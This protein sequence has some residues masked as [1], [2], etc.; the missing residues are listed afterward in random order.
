[1]AEGRTTAGD[2]W[3]SASEMIISAAREHS[4]R[5]AVIDADGSEINYA[6]MSANVLSLAGKLRDLGVGPDRMVAVMLPRSAYSVAAVAAILAAGGTYCPLDG[7]A[8]RRR[9]AGLLAA[10]APTVVLTDGGI[11]AGLPRGAAVLDPAGGI[12]SAS[13]EGT[14]APPPGEPRRDH[15]AYVIHTSGSTGHPKGVAMTHRGLNRLLRW[16][17][18]SGPAELRTLQFT[19]TGFDVTFQEVLS[20]LAT[21]GTLVIPTDEQRR[22]PAR[23]LDVV[24]E[25]G[26][27]RLF[28]PYVALQQLAVVA[29]TTGEF[30]ETL[31]HVVT[32]GERL[33]VTDAIAELFA[34]L[35]GCRLDNHYGPTEA[36]LVTAGT[37]PAD[38]AA[39]PQ[40]PSI[41]RP[42]DGVGCRVLDSGLEPVP[43]GKTGELYVSGAGLARGYLGDPALTAA[44]FL[45]DPF[46]QPGARMYRTGDLVRTGDDGEYEFVGR[47]D[48]QLKVRGFRVEPAEVEA[49]ILG[50]P[51]ITGAAVG[52]REV[53]RGVPALVAYVTAEGPLAH[54]ALVGFL[55]ERLPV[56]LIPART[57]VLPTL[58]V[59]ANGKV[60]A[61]A[62]AAVEL[63]ASFEHAVDTEVTADLVAEIWARVLG[64][65]DFEP[66]DDFFDVG[67]DSLL[68]SWVVAELGQALGRPVD[69]SLFLEDSTVD[70]LVAALARTVPQAPGERPASQIV[71]L[72]AGPS[73]R[74]LYLLHPLGGELVGYRELV[75]ATR[76]PLRALGVGWAGEPPAPGTA[77]PD[78]AAVHFAQL[79]TIQPHGPYLLAGWSFGGVLAYELA[80]QLAAAGEEV[81]FLGLL[82]AN[83]VLDPL[84]A[85]PL[86]ET[87]HAGVLAAALDRLADGADLA[88]LSRD[89]SWTSLMGAPVPEGAP[90]EHLRRSL[91]IA[92]T[93]MRAAMDYRPAAYAGPLDLFQAADAPHGK[94]AELA[95]VLRR[96]CTGRFTAT[97]VPGDHWGITREHAGATAAAIDSALE[98][99]GEQNGHH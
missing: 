99:A 77:L 52:L 46:G 92:H 22:N 95:G 66:D 59:G 71:T 87:R 25:R 67:G 91:G 50:H 10:L 2:E 8:P 11:P 17:V 76:S 49:A 96:L 32:A 68:A 6:D 27:Q 72:R 97:T 75:K 80:R 69:L 24:R 29:Q 74:A 88:A 41:G 54:Q 45:P 85:L 39:W 28:L 43:D 73:T 56:Y 15:L 84:T 1:M 40:L 31:E 63:P 3:F 26:I 78:I 98:R 62:L 37:L 79:R 21:G 35:P 83:P 82:D 5:I 61:K 55:H 19:A 23:L 9:T 58:P 7:S 65:D 18:A 38:R 44:R 93:C 12:L 53:A 51:R 48:R 20:T 14:V 47:A 30:P 57:L 94:Q 33:I 64:H 4:G 36:H 70:D 34:K 90:A 89:G 42:V 81:E 16:Q 60:D 13:Q 86:G